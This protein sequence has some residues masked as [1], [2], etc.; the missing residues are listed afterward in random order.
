MKIKEGSWW[1]KWAY[2]LTSEYSYRPEAGDTINLCPLFWRIVL[3]TPLKILGLLIFSPILIVL[4]P[5]AAL[6]IFWDDKLKR[7]VANK[8]EDIADSIGDKFNPIIE[9]VK[10]IKNKYCPRI[11]VTE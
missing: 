5:V 6:A 8:T 2:L 7:I 10:A 9:G 4:A 11:E 3:I 1:I